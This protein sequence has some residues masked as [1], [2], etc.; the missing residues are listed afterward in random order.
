MSA[1]AGGQPS[2]HVAKATTSLPTYF[3]AAILLPVERSRREARARDIA[4]SLHTCRLEKISRASAVFVEHV[5]GVWRSQK[6]LQSRLLAWSKHRLMQL[7][8]R[9]QPA[10]RPT[11]DYDCDLSRPREEQAD[12]KHEGLLG[13]S[14]PIMERFSRF[15]D[16]GTGIQVYLQPVPVSPMRRAMILDLWLT[17]PLRLFEC[18]WCLLYS[19]LDRSPLPRIYSHP[20]LS[21]WVLQEHCCWS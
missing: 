1:R 10:Q 8:L 6:D 13:A 18:T 12:H 21:W 9:L 17:R 19:L 5:C 20:L 14:L 4:F 16:P 2:H 15:R 7:F 11:H 3:G